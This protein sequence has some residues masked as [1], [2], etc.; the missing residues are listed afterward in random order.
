MPSLTIKIIYSFKHSND[1]NVHKLLK[2][3]IR[4]YKVSFSN[5]I[6]YVYYFTLKSTFGNYFITVRLQFI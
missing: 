2:K 1:L 4:G 3:R 5:W 6:S